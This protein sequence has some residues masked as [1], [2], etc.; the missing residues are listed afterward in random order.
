MTK[1][2]SAASVDLDEVARFSAIADEWWDPHG[3]FKPLHQINPVR[4]K[5][6]LDT[7]HQSP[8]TAHSSELRTPNSELSVLDIG[9]GGGLLCE[10]MARLGATVTGIDASDTNINIA[11]TH[12]KHSE[13]TIHYRATTA[14]AL[15]NESKQ[16]NLVLNMEVIEHVADVAAFMEAS[17]AL[18]KPGG[19][20]ILSTINRTP[21]PTPWPSSVQS[22]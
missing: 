15:R 2:A 7:S 5:F 1:T 4:L 19:R 14:E 18:V 11:R 22:T 13:L 16:F 12:A 17:C 9:C 10:P 21:K 3:K 20:M 6:I 8:I